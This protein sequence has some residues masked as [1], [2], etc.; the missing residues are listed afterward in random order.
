MRMTLSSVLLALVL[1]A[2]PARAQQTDTFNHAKHA[3]VFPSCTACHAGAVDPSAPLLPSGQGCVNCHDGTIQRRVAWKAPQIEANNLRF[4]HAEHSRRLSARDGRDST[5]ACQ[6]CHTPAGGGWMTVQLA[7]VPQCLT[8]HGVKTAHLAA[9]DTACATCHLPLAQATALSAADVK[10]FPEPPSHTTPGFMGPSGH[11]ALA[12]AGT[13]PTTY[14]IAPSC[15]TCHARDFCITCHVNAPETAAIQALAPD[16]RS[17]A[18]PVELEAPA[19]HNQGGFLSTHGKDAR[20]STTSCQTCHTQQSC[21]ACHVSPPKPVTALHAAGPGR[22]AGAQIVRSRPAMH[23]A[24]FS[25]IH[26]QVASSDQQSC[27][28]CHVRAQCLDCHRGTPER[29]PQYHPQTFLARHPAAAYARETNCADCHN[30]AAFC[31]NCHVQSGLGSPRGPLVSGYH[32]VWP[33]FLLNHGQTARQNLESCTS[34]HTEKDCMTCHSALYGRG[35]NP[36]GP[37]F[38]A[39][40]LRKANPQMCTAC[41]GLLIP[42]AK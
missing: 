14:G 33:G 13:G 11:A 41:H 32:D 26:S 39:D 28:A 37:G 2:S 25:T 42:G 36:H 6:A 38:D 35:F 4:T 20:K 34:C 30:S 27:Q 9:P 16:P 22:G 8:C 18:I 5:L 12:R 10:G 15:A 23:M 24:D 7:V 40:K 3:K 21:M 31:Q 29:T 19:S 1:A 17:L